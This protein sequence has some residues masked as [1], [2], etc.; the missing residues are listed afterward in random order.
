MVENDSDSF[1]IGLDVQTGEDRWRIQRPRAA[2]WTSPALWR[3]QGRTLVL[4]Q[5]SR[6]VAAVDPR[7]GETV[8]NYGDGAST[9]PSLVAVDGLAFVPSHGITAIR[10]GTTTPEV[11]EIVWQEGN[12]APGTASP[13][14]YDDSVFVLSNPNVLTRAAAA[15]GEV[16]WKTRLT[17][18]FS[19]SPVIAGGFLFVFNE[20]GV[21]H[22]VDIADKGKTIGTIDL[23]ETIMSTPA[24]AGG[25]LYIRSD[26][27]LWK[28]TGK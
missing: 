22:V 4:L 12:L 18:N 2:N 11:A 9:I 3:G 21:G 20:D 24:I 15:D 25:A 13:L 1:T 28:I 5:S 19:G 16:Q 14:V 7:T 23:G 10:P 27:H 6:G 17:G 8:W 26:G